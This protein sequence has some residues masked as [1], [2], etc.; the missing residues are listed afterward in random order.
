M[1]Y[2]LIEEKTLEA[3]NTKLNDKI[4]KG[5]KV[6]FPHYVRYEVK[7][8]KAEERKRVAIYSILLVKEK[9]KK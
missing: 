3:F 6:Q 7:A 1:V 2:E 4:S 8:L 9:D 5:F